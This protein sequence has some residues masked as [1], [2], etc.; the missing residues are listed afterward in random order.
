MGRG[1]GIYGV[2]LGSVTAVAI[3]SGLLTPDRHGFAI[4]IFGQAIWFL[5]VASGMWGL[6]A[7]AAPAKG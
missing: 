3:C 6:E 4:L 1:V 2:V 5:L 7:K